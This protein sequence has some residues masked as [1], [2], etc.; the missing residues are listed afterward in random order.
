MPPN[1]K[2]AKVSPT[3]GARLKIVLGAETAVGP[4]KADLLDQIAAT[5]SIAAAGRRMSMSYRRAWLLV[6]ELN[7]M[8]KTPVVTTSK[9]GKG[10]G[11][12]A[13][14][15]AF[16]RDVLKRYRR[17]QKTTAKAIADDLRALRK[18]LRR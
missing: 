6:D 11:G 7:G 18:E 17:M 10:G 8:F 15:T 14:I 3:I 16:G 2:R 9:G 5:G 12:G 1:T 4:G 13:Q